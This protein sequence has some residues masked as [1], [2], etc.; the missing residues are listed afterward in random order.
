MALTFAVAGTMLASAQHAAA[1]DPEAKGTVTASAA[2]AA[3]SSDTI[4]ISVTRAVSDQAWSLGGVGV[5]L[6]PK[7]VWGCC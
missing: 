2:L 3:N 7:E 5:L 1:V 4:T 6:M